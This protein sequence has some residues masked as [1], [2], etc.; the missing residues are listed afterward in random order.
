MPVGIWL[1]VCVEHRIMAGADQLADFLAEGIHPGSAAVVDDREAFLGIGG[2][3]SRQTAALFVVNEKDRD[4]GA[5][6]ITLAVHFVHVAVALVGKPPQVVEVRP[7]LDVVGLIGV[8]ELQLNVLNAANTEGMIGFLDRQSDKVVGD[9]VI[10]AGGS[11]R[12]GD[13]Q[14]D[15]NIAVRS[16]GWHYI[17][18]DKPIQN[19][20]VESFNG[21]LRDELFLQSGSGR[22]VQ[23][24]SVSVMGSCFCPRSA[25][26]AP[27]VGGRR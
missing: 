25:C 19:A 3:A 7:A 10:V 6:A 27:H 14:R 17:A 18:P 24:A 15:R 1:V 20:F 9:V 2:I 4:V 5:D 8:D 22:Q 16:V 12:I 11:G 13:Q 26:W 23:M 21:R